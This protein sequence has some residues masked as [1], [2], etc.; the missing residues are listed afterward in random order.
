MINEP[1]NQF[2]DEKELEEVS[3]RFT[4]VSGDHG[5]ECLTLGV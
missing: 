3:L 5:Y 2:A 1:Q 4:N